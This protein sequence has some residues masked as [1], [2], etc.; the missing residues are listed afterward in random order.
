MRLRVLL[1]AG[2]SAAIALSLMSAG[3]ATASDAERV[4]LTA[5]GS[6]VSAPS[7]AAG[8]ASVRP[9]AT[10]CGTAFGTPVQDGILSWDG[11]GFDTA[12]A[13]DF[14]CRGKKRK[15]TFGTVTVQGTFGDP[16]TTLFDVTVYRN[17]SSGS[18]NE[19]DNGSAPQCA[20][21]QVAGAPTGAQFPSFDT[22]VITLSTKCTAQKGK[23]NWLEVQ[24]VT[25][26]GQPWY[27]RTQ[28]N[29]GGS[30]DA[31]WR[32]TN[33]SFGTACTPGYIDDAYMQDCVFGGP[34][35]E[36]DFMFELST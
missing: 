10:K 21:Q 14:T 28:S 34:A 26:S 4:P 16:G 3:T 18:L 25:T 27:W 2:A 24:A 22:T 11:S 35:G 20:T 15:R 32:D 31:D 17:D 5:A 9:M 23:V 1:A 7:P 33:N 30:Y 8:A 13:A 29:T 6:S 36:P 12:G 19:P